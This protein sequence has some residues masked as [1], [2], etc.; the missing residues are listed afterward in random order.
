MLLDVFGFCPLHSSCIVGK[1]F[2][3]HLH[4]ANTHH[5]ECKWPQTNKNSII[6]QRGRSSRDLL[7]KYLCHV[8]SV[9][10]SSR[11]LHNKIYSV[12]DGVILYYSVCITF[13]INVMFQM[14]QMANCIYRK[15]YFKYYTN[16]EIPTK[17]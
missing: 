4:R 7:H 14:Y 3:H 12:N 5:N 16:T 2:P 9:C 1:C 8:A 17:C 6:S 15:Y 11:K 10:M 13:I